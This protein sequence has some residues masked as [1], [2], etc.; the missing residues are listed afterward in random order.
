MPKIFRR[1]ITDLLTHQINQFEI[2]KPVTDKLVEILNKTGHSTIIDLCSGSGGPALRMRE[3]ASQITG[4]DIHLILTDKYP[5]LE[6]F[7]KIR[8]KHVTPILEPTDALK[9]PQD[10]R[11]VRTLFTSFH[12]FKPQQAKEI[13]ENA[14]NASMPIGIFEITERK[15]ASLMTLLVAPITCLI[16]SFFIRPRKLS[17]FFWTYI[18][19]IIPL[20]Y[21][22]DGI[23][24]NIRTYTKKEY[25]EMVGPF[26]DHFVWETGEL[27]SKFHIKISYL[28]GYP[29]ENTEK[30]ID[31]SNRNHF[32]P[33]LIE[34]TLVNS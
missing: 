8:E 9:V 31:H 6:I 17:R 11:G 20:L 4:R 18:I 2:Y 25:C 14:V 3:N 32:N 33:N 16:F 27:I 22:W 15:P 30:V 10:L 28:I 24:S 13:L 21:T 29:K 12:H 7:K 34:Q 23:V 26:E 5:N 1:Y 19:P